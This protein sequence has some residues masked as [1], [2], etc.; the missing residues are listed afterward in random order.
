MTS[1]E[2]LV[3]KTLHIYDAQ[4]YDRLGEVL[5]EDV[6]L[7]FLGETSVGIDHVRETLQALYAALP[8]QT[9]TVDRLTV[10]EPNQAVGIEMTVAGTHTGAP[11]PTRF[12]EIPTSGRSVSWNPGSF[13]RA[14]DGKVESWTV[15]LD[16]VRVLSE[17]GVELTTSI[18]A[19]SL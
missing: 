19:A 12:G 2:A 14:R 7:T 15:Y 6:K 16:Q 10:D 8:D 5:H 17:F 3:R 9:H 13:M 18:P 1:V 11:F 4:E